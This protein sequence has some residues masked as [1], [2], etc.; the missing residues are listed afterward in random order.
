MKHRDF[1]PCALCGK[2]MMHRGDPTFFEVTIGRRII[3]PGAVNRAVGMELMMGGNA[4]LANLMGPDEDLAVAVSN[5]HKVLI[6]TP[7]ALSPQGIAQIE[8]RILDAAEEADASEA[9]TAP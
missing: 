2:G 9:V 3:S 1:K 8:E 4:E 6:C 5:D 7:C